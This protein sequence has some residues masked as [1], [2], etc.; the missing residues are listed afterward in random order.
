MRVI[1]NAN[2][3]NPPQSI[4]PNDLYEYT[5]GWTAV[6]LR[7]FPLWEF[8]DIRHEA[9]VAGLGLIPKYD[10]EGAQVKGYV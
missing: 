5:H 6:R 10:P 3:G 1:G 7:S 2:M 8:D 4:S 9:Y